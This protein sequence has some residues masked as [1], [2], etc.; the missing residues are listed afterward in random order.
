M[1]KQCQSP[2][3]FAAFTLIEILVVIVIIGII[4]A[5]TIFTV[6]NV[7]KSRRVLATATEIQG[8]LSL[9]Q[10]QA[11]LT[12]SVLGFQVTS[13]GYSFYTFTTDKDRESMRLNPAWIPISDST[14]LSKHTTIG[15]IKLSITVGDAPFKTL[16]QFIDSKSENKPQILILPSGGF[17]PFT[18]LIHDND[19]KTAYSIKGDMAGNLMMKPVVTKK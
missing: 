1:T 6:G 11:I 14:I 2:N 4:T 8:A 15:F 7:G 12:S 5:T 13:H 18:L 19:G 17:T 16:Q 9:A 10:E 3:N